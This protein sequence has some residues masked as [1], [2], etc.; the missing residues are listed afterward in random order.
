MN[1]IVVG[2]DGSDGAREAVL[3]AARTA[4]DRGLEL[5]IVHGQRVVEFAYG[6]G[7]AGAA[8]VFEAIRAEAVQIIADA[9]EQAKSVSDALVVTTEMPVDHPVVLL[10]EL[11]RTADM[12]VVGGTG[13][14]GFAGVLAGSTAVRVASHAHCPVAVIRKAPD[15]DTVP[16][17][18]PVVVG[19]DGSPNSEKAIAV[20]FAEASARG[21]A[22]VA[23]H[24]W[25]DT[26]YDYYYGSARLMV[27]WESFAEEEERLLA[28]RLAGW[29]EKYPDVEVRKELLKDRPR[30]ALLAAAEDARLVVVGSHG[31]GGFRGMLLGSTSL[32]LVQHANCPVLVVRPEKN[33]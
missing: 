10:N 9:V 19:V 3:W 26:T 29:R 25:T 4:A 30:H 17:S 33:R 32:A 27:A 2:V 31:R 14:S 21:A 13:H 11:S 28:Q 12:V 6:G 24:A 18:G 1:R 20:A 8:G 23:M 15:A 22:L 7:L 16:V 5:H